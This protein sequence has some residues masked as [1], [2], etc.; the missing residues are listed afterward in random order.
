[1]S[2]L[3]TLQNSSSIFYWPYVVSTFLI[4]LLWLLFIEQDA[5]R[6]L[7]KTSLRKVVSSPTLWAD[8]GLT[9]GYMVLLRA[10]IAV[11][12]A[13]AFT[14]TLGSTKSAMSAIALGRFV[15]SP[16]AEG[17]GATVVT[18]LA[19]DLAS[20]VVHRLM[21]TI[22]VFWEIHALHHSAEHL[23][24]FTTY[25][26]HP[27]EPLLLY[28]F[29]GAAAGIA[30]G[31]FHSIFPQATPVIRIWGMGAGFF[32]YMF[33]V[34]LH[35]CPVA[36]TYPKWLRVVAMSP[37][38]HHI[39]HS[40]EP[41]HHQHNFGVVF[42]FWDRMF[43]THL[44]EAVRTGE[45]RFGIGQRTNL[46]SVTGLLLGPLLYFFRSKTVSAKKSGPTA[47]KSLRLGLP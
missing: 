39:H 2:F 10:P 13:A 35:H 37:H 36:V 24:P 41:R 25:R 20:Y 18:M 4:S 9:F 21:H 12:E 23:S 11:L 8:V 16:L 28:G 38:M 31:V 33:T 14:A 44:D 27:L 6:V 46:R 1:M 19:I 32:I 45:L 29:R 42:S 7:A 15:A 34:N 26:Q 17:I 30:L 22:P 3:E 5:L 40:A 43:R 47:S